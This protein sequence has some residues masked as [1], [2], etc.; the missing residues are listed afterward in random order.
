M[1]HHNSS[2]DILCPTRRSNYISSL[3]TDIGCNR[4]KDDLECEELMMPFH[5]LLKEDIEPVVEDSE[6]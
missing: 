1:V 2:F 4:S 6:R 3:I 5:D